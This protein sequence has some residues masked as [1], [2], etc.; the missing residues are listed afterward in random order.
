[1]IDY[2]FST[3]DLE[4][5]LLVFI[6][7]VSFMNLAPFYGDSSIP[8]RFKVGLSLALSY[9]VFLLT[10]HTEL[11]Y[12]TVTEYAALVVMEAAVGLLIGLVSTVCMQIASMAGRLVDMEIGLS[13]ASTMDPS[14]RDNVTV[15]G[16][17]YRYAFTLLF[18]TSGMYQYVIKAFIQTYELIPVGDVHFALDKILSSLITFMGQYF[19]IGFQI[20]MPVFAVITVMNAVL[21]VLAKVAP[22]MNLFAVGMQLKILVGLAVLYLSMWL[23]PQAADSMFTQMKKMIV[24]MVEALM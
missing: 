5:F 1:M 21:G 24:S 2:S 18:I 22:Q 6:R 3:S 8:A 11:V 16:L 17:I 15:S 13:A 7:I 19:L 12:S 20:A 23:V 10:P 14:Y 4:Y 9:M